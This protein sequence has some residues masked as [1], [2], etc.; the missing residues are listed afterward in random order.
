MRL[1]GKVAVV[2]GGG[3]DIGRAVSLRLAAEGARVVV[4]YRNDEAQARATADEIT[5]AGGTAV[6]IRAD[7]TS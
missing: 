3:R 6:L 1:D 7:M 4:N 5:A 2:T